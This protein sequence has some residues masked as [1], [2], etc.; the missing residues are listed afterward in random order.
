MITNKIYWTRVSTYNQYPFLAWRSGKGRGNIIILT[1]EPNLNHKKHKSLTNNIEAV[2][3]HI[4]I[5]MYFADEEISK[6]KWYQ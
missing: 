5:G 3:K 1:E 6:I 4:L 2:L